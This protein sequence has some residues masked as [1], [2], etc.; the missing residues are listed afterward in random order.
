MNAE[1][2]KADWEY[3][4]SRLGEDEVEE[5]EETTEREMRGCHL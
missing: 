1:M 5:S 4:A 2:L 3:I